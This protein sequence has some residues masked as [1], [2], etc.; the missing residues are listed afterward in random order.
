M[1]RCL[2]PPTG[3]VWAGTA[4]MT[5]LPVTGFDRWTADSGEMRWRL[6][7]PIPA[8][9]ATGTD[10][11]RSATGPL[12]REGAALQAERTFGGITIP[13]RLRA[14]WAWETDRQS[15]VE[16]FRAEITAATFT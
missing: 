13:T 1:A 11:S 4:R 8:A 9:S 5:G 16:F 15:D 7:G 12:A 10:I 2:A 14:G 3:F 6:M